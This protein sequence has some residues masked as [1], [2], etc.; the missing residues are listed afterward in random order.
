MNV[1]DTYDDAKMFG[2]NTRKELGERWKSCVIAVPGEGQIKYSVQFFRDFP[3]RQITIDRI[4][5]GRLG[6]SHFWLCRMDWEI[7]RPEYKTHD[8]ETPKDA[9]KTAVNRVFEEI[10]EEKERLD[11]LQRI[12]FDEVEGDIK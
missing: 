12:L 9:L 8:G 7:D 4:S 11:E 10:Q 3:T 2:D 1:W 6:N 5:Y